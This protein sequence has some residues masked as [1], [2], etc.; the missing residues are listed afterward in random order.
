M[1]ACNWLTG[2]HIEKVRAFLQTRLT[3]FGEWL[4]SRA[5]TASQES[6]QQSFF[7]LPDGVMV[8]QLILVQFVEVRILVGQPSLIISRNVDPPRES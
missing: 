7:W 5:F 6:W 3:S 4:A 8:A 2:W 1:V